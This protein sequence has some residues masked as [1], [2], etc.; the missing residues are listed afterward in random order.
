LREIRPSKVE[1]FIHRLRRGPARVGWRAMPALMRAGTV[2]SALFVAIWL[3]FIPLAAFDVGD[4]SLNGRTVTGPYFLAHAYPV[5][6]PFLAL[7]AALAYGYWTERL[8]AR[9]LPVIFWL[10]V[11]GVLFWEI[12]AHEVV[13]G[14]ATE[15]VVWAILYVVVALWY[16][17]YKPSVA[18]YYR[19]L[20]RA[21]G[22]GTAASDAGGA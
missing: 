6:L 4:Y 14:E 21:Y 11:D 22:H 9:P 8:W 12:L 5:L 13:G 16:C 2:L 19:A 20:E 18:A 10:A 1:V 17:F 3:G 7:C 15:F